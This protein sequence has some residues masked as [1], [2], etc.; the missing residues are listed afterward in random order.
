MQS[1]T[2][3]LISAVQSAE[4]FYTYLNRP[5]WFK[6]HFRPVFDALRRET[7]GIIILARAGSQIVGHIYVDLTPKHRS[8]GQ[9]VPIFGWLDGE[10]PEIIAELLTT[11]ESY[12]H[13]QGF[14]TLRGPINVPKMFGGWGVLLHQ[15]DTDPLIDTAWNRPE[16][17]AWLDQ[18]GY[19]RAAV[20]CNKHAAL[21]DSMRPVNKFP[22]ID[23]V[24]YP[25][26]ELVQEHPKILQQIGIF[27]QKTFGSFLPDTY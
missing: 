10:S 23:F 12:V 15:F 22:E 19:Q 26:P 8:F 25:I 11:A 9:S 20:Y 5:A 16:L 6:A 21:P 3:Q 17:A 14:A 1:L 24:S 7:G 4:P 18:A 27:I 2:L 13:E